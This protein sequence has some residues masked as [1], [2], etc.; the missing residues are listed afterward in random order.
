MSEQQTREANPNWRGGR[1]I[2]EHGYVLIKV[3]FD[4][5]LAD[6]RGYAYEH[7]LVAEAKLGRRLRNDEHVHHAD[8]NKSNNDPANLEVLTVAEHR[9]EHRKPTS[10][11]PPLG[12]HNE[13]IA[14]ACGC[15]EMFDKL[16]SLGRIRRFV[17]GHNEHPSPTVDAVLK[18]LSS[19]PCT[20]TAVVLAT[21]LSKQAVA[22]CLSKLK[23]AKRARNVG[24]GLWEAVQ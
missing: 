23:K 17:S 19:G 10:K 21:G 9:A 11:L 1:T 7:R 12:T 18:A 14:C 22:V 3:G 24:R 20:R 4:H 2:T 15:G 16:D 13:K 6:V 8:H 5:H